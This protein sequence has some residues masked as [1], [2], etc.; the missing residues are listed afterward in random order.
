[1][2]ALDTSA[3]V[4]I[5]RE[6]P[7]AAAFSE[8]IAGGI[9]LVG[10]PTLLEASMILPSMVTQVAADR[11][12]RQFMAKSWVETVPFSLGMFEAARLAFEMFGKGRHPAKLNFG[13]CMS[14]AVA[15][16]RDVPLL[17]KGS[18]FSRTDIVPAYTP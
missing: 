10:T 3:L 8:V 12:L 7:E 14:Y 6:E 17:F 9:V 11:F 2:I 16:V 18:D 4:V 15:K 1:M 5:A 13:D